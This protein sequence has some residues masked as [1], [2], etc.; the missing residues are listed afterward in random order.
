MRKL[1]DWTMKKAGHK[2]ALGWLSFISFLESSVFPIPPDIMLIPMIMAQ[3]EKAFKIALICTLAS[4]AGG[5]AG[6]AVGYFLYESIGKWVLDVYHLTEKFTAFSAAFNEYGAWIVLIKGMTPIP[7][8]LIT[9]AAGSV[10]MDL[11]VFTMASIASRAMRFFLVAALLWWF[12]PAIQS[13]IEKRLTLV[14][15]IFAILL[16]SGFVIV[17]LL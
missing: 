4:V 3:R 17:K 14:T 11:L 1:Y 16:V 9:I 12:G 8:K 7:Y 5:W 15:T 2:H 13:F 10:K 6:Y